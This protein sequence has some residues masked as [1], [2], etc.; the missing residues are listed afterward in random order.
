MPLRSDGSGT[1]ACALL[2]MEFGTYVIERERMEKIE[3]QSSQSVM[4]RTSLRGSK[5]GH[6]DIQKSSKINRHSVGAVLGPALAVIAYLCPIAGLSFDAHIVLSIM[7]LVCTWWITEPVPIPVTSLIGPVLCVVF[8]ITTASDAFSAFANPIIFLFLGGF[9]LARAMTVHGLDKRFS[10][11]L[12]SMK[13]VGSNPRRIFIAIG[14]ASMLCSGWISNTATAAMM[15]PIALGLLNT[16]AEMMDQAGQKIDLKNYKYATGL[17]LITA[18]A[19]SIGGVLTPI[20]TPPNMLM[21]GFL[22]SMV[23]VHISFF[24]WMIWGFVA[25]VVYF[26]LAAF[27]VGRMFPPDVKE[28]KGADKLIAERR[29]SLGP[30]TRGQKNTL[31]AFVLAVVLWVLPGIFSMVFGSE[32]PQVKFIDAH[33]PEAVVA[34]IGAILLFLI[35]EGRGKQTL[36]WKEASD[37][38][39][40]GT[41]ILFGGGL[42][43]GQ[44]M[45]KSGL[46]EWIG[47]G[48]VGGLGGT[49]SQ[50]V[51]IMTFSV[52]ALVMS[53]VTSHTAATN[54]VGPLGI[55]TAIAAG[56][57]PV[58]VA[59]AIALSASLGFM[60]PV[61]TPPNAIVYASGY[62]PITKMLKTGVIIDFV[63]IFAITIPLVLFLV[64]AVV[65]V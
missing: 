63:G 25:M 35:P 61:S 53:E 37:G 60:L 26:I 17:M 10:Y 4:T 23:D 39:D 20:G 18:Y 8:G 2:K 31:F 7:L 15:L 49:P 28:I 64:T 12:L 38:V 55:T 6:N 40:W 30:W 65:G 45:Y 1:N 47:N 54:M 42:S 3:K 34:L 21:M 62:V 27:V 16:I 52:L 29:K 32:S 44:V 5:K 57:N 22:D 46:S 11:A 14:L 9:I 36:T 43:L 48:I 51:L 58:P 19:A 41:L 59:V 50:I 24:Q 33:F 13:W 56:L